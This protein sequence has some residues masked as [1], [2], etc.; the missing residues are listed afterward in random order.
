V[1][2]VADRLATRGD[3]SEAAID[4]HL[5]LAQQLLTEALSWAANPPRA[6]VRGDELAKALGVRPGP[7]IGTLL[8]RLRE[9][10]FTGEIATRDEAIEHARR[11]TE[12]AE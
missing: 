7:A 11:L 1:L 2:S 9:A 12:R 6:P 3:G 8:E 10:S 4:R 5:E